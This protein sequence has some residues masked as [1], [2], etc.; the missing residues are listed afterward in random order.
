MLLCL[1][2]FHHFMLLCMCGWFLQKFSVRRR[3]QTSTQHALDPN[4][5][6]QSLPINQHI[7]PNLL[8]ELRNRR[9]TDD[10]TM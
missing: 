3:R 1:L 7:M 6:I 8:P 2:S 10:I 4:D 9:L 5:K